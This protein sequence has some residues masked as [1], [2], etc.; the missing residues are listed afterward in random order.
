MYDTVASWISGEWPAETAASS[1]W[2][3]GAEAIAAHLVRS[4][5][6]LSRSPGATGLSALPA[7]L[8]ATLDGVPVGT[9]TLCMEDLPGRDAEFGPWLAALFV[10]AAHRG[11]GVARAL[12]KAA[13]ALARRLNLERLSLWLLKSEPRLKQMYEHF[14]WAVTQEIT[15]SCTS[16]AVGQDVDVIVMHAVG[17]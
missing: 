13:L 10:P 1:G 3:N 5:L 17:L 12:M 15:C 7:T 8:V 4:T 9:V 14:G 2:G 16:A 6:R 11:Q